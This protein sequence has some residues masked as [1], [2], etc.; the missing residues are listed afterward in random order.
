MRAAQWLISGFI[1]AL[2]V[3]QSWAADGNGLTANAESVPWARWQ[4]RMSFEI[5]APLLRSDLGGASAAAGLQIRSVS[6]LR[7]YYLTRPLIG[8]GTEGG[9]HTTSGLIL[10]SGS[11][12]AGQALFGAQPTAL[13]VARRIAAP[14][15]PSLGAD[16]GTDGSATIPYLGVGY[17]GQ[18]AKGGWRFSADLGLIALAAGNAVK[19]GRVFSGSQSLDDLAREMR[20]APVMQMGLSYSF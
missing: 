4:G 18:S 15:T 5:Q 14:V 16:A 9:L 17:M 19:F 10:S 3:A 12:S 20:V 2:P 11:R 7:D 13:S 6:L 1:A 8:A